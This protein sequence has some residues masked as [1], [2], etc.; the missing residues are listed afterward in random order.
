MRNVEASTRKQCVGRDGT[1]G[2]MDARDRLRPSSPF[3]R[4]G[5][6]MPI[7]TRGMYVA[8]ITADI[9][10]RFRCLTVTVLLGEAEQDAVLQ[11]RPMIGWA[12]PTGFKHFC[13]DLQFAH[14][15]STCLKAS[16]KI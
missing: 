12:R 10:F 13:L 9:H 16:P 6:T 7:D 11:P 4:A 15:E 5:L 8:K 14:T 2:A 3:A 1:N